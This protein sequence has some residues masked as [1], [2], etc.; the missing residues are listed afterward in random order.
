M[1]TRRNVLFI[2]T[3]FQLR[4]NSW[5]WSFE[6]NGFI[7]IF[8]IP[9]IKKFVIFNYVRQSA[10]AILQGMHARRVQDI[11]ARV[12]MPQSPRGQFVAYTYAARNYM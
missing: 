4:N 3:E 5:P 1:L 9:I 10:F 8:L 12:V 7:Q 6:L 11:K 2:W